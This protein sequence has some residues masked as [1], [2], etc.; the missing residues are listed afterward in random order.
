MPRRPLIVGVLAIQ[1]AL[2][3]SLQLVTDVTFL[4]PLLFAIGFMAQTVI[5]QSVLADSTDREQLDQVFGF[6]YT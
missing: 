2:Y 6:Y 3:Y 1:G 4:A 5:M